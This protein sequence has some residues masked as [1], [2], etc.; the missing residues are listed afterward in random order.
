M[1]LLLIYYNY[2]LVE[3]I[4]TISFNFYLFFM[5]LIFFLFNISFRPLT[6]DLAQFCP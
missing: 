6:I 1:D 5:E 2:L 4:Y 3:E